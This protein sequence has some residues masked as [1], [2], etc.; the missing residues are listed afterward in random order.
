MCARVIYK[1]INCR[2]LKLYISLKIIFKYIN[3]TARLNTVLPN[4]TIMYSRSAS[5]CRDASNR[6]RLIHEYRLRTESY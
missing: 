1:N 6:V 2:Q 3:A 5:R 4:V